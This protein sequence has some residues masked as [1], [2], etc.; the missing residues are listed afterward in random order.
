VAGGFEFF[1]DRIH[2]EKQIKSLLP[3]EAFSEIPEVLTTG[4][5]RSRKARAVLGWSLAAVFICA[6]LLGS[7]FSYLHS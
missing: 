6:I 7:A 4:Q 1:D 2:S 3:M 5:Q